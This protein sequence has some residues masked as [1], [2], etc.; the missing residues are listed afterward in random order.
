MEVSLPVAV[1][2][3]S[4][5]Q[6]H[7]NPGVST[8]HALCAGEEPGTEKQPVDTRIAREDFTAAIGDF[9]PS[10][11]TSGLSGNGWDVRSTRK[12]ICIPPLPSWKVRWESIYHCLFST[13]SNVS[14]GHSSPAEQ[15]TEQRC[16]ESGGEPGGFR[17]DGCLLCIYL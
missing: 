4:G 13:G 9:L 16:R 7:R 17:G 2:F 10:V 15:A 14:T 1:W 5:E 8:L 12:R 11:S 6:V 3:G